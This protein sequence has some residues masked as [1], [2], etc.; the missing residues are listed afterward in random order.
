MSRSVQLDPEGG[1]PSPAFGVRRAVGPSRRGLAGG[2]RRVAPALPR[3]LGGRGRAAG[4]LR[5]DRHGGVSAAGRAA[6]RAVH[7]HRGGLGRGGGRSAGG[8]GTRPGR[9][10]AWGGRL[11]ARSTRLLGHGAGRTRP[12]RR[13]TRR[14]RPGRRSAAAHRARPRHAG[15]P[16]RA[17]RRAPERHSAVGA[18]RVPACARRR[19]RPTTTICCAPS[20]GATSR[21]SPCATGNSP[22]HGTASANRCGCARSWAFWSAWLRR[23]PPS[24]TS[25]PSPRPPGYAQEAGRLFRLLGGV[26]VWLADQLSSS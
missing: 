5:G 7:V 8:R 10:G 23:W 16:P 24:P 15:L 25:S 12:V 22:R 26:P 9:R 20:P 6:G 18:R 14:A 21:G 4:P 3:L 19:E 11:R 13:G 1:E 2:P 17:A